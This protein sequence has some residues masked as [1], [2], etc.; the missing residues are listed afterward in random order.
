MPKLTNALIANDFPSFVHECHKISRDGKALNP[1]PYLKLAFELAEDVANGIES[2]AIVNL[3]PG[4][5]KSFIFAVCLPAWFLAHHPSASIMIVEHSKK[6]ARDTTRSILRILQSE[7]FKRN[8]TT[9]ID[10]NWQGAG[11]FGTTK[12]GSVFATSIRG[13]ITGYRADL[14]V[15]DDPLPIKKAN[16]IDEIEF[17][18]ETFNDEIVSR[19]RDE[20]SRI[21]VVMHRLHENDL[22]GHLQREGGY[23]VLAVPLLVER[24]TTYSS[25]Y[26]VWEREKGELIRANRY[27]KKELRDLAFEPSFRFLFQQGKGGGASLRVKSKHFPLLD[28]R[29]DRSL[30]FVFSIDTAQKG[31]AN[32]SRMVIQVWQPDGVNHYL[33]DVFSA[34]CDY[35]R[36][37]EALVYLVRRYPPAMIL[38][39]DTASGSALI[40]QAEARLQCS[41][42]GVIP[43]GSKFERF[44]RHFDTI[45]KGRIHLPESADWVADWIAEIVAFPNGDYDDHVDG[46]SMYLDFVATHPVMVPNV[47]GGGLGSLV[48]AS[49]G[50]YRVPRGGEQSTRGYVASSTSP[51]LFQPSARLPN[52]RHDLDWGSPVRVETPLG[53]VIVRRR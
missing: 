45:R 6:L 10:E 37:W 18:N 5:A 42:I 47:K 25:R 34:K 13:T 53:T 8:F 26:G 28:I 27:T 15:V 49:G 19:T 50:N 22:T 38:I 2:R 1:D 52:G 17:V 24:P 31:N 14:I 35:T 33:I 20:D 32:S 41:V 51:R 3:P 36:L 39:E 46:L 23:K 40:A 7:S 30:P 29:A 48:G 21:L 9:R 43:K 11:D 16:N 12:A 4:T 44:R